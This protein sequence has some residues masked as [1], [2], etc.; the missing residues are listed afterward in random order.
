M[1]RKM[2]RVGAAVAAGVLLAGLA[3]CGDDDDAEASSDDTTGVASDGETASAEFCDAVVEVDS[4]NLALEN[5]EADQAEVEATMDEA[6]ELAPEAI[7]D[8]AEVLVTESKEM[9]AQPE[10]EDGPP[11]IPSDEFFASSVAVGD[12]VV[13]NCDMGSV[14]VTATEYAFD[15]IAESVPAGTTVFR[16]DN[17]GQE[18]HEV[19]LMK[20]ADGET[21]SAEELLALPEEEAM[22]V[23]TPAGFVFAP[24]GMGSY[25]TA[26]LEPGR[27]VALCFV[28]V[29]AT[30]EAMAAGDALADAAPHFTH[31][32]VTEFQVD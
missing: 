20:V 4:A 11:V 13:D 19:A 7:A 2:R 29:G 1:T 28:P 32:M 9:A 14:D 17:A 12:Y 8:D 27:Y 23:V 15:G 21:R 26:E 16:F 24:P 22:A 25:I 31:G 5:G 6:L 18:F 3:A 10:T 30:P